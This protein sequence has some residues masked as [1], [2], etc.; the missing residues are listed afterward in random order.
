MPRLVQSGANVVRSEMDPDIM[1]DENTIISQL[2]NGFRDALVYEE[3]VEPWAALKSH[4]GYI[5]E[6]GQLYLRIQVVKL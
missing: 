4:C 1:A 5:V 2:L 3:F 6:N